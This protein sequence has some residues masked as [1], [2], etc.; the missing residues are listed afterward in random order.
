MKIPDVFP[1]SPLP[2]WGTQTGILSDSFWILPESELEAG[3]WLKASQIPGI[4][5]VNQPRRSWWIQIFK[6]QHHRV[7]CDPA[8]AA[9]AAAAVEM[10]RQRRHTA[11]NSN[12]FVWLNNLTAEE[13]EG[14][15]DCC[16]W[17]KRNETEQSRRKRRRRRR[18]R[19][20]RRRRMDQNNLIEETERSFNFDG[21]GTVWSLGHGT[22][23]ITSTNW[24]HENDVRDSAWAIVTPTLTPALIPPLLVTRNVTR[25]TAPFRFFHSV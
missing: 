20:R 15:G 6:V 4:N 11:S 16:F 23:R 9:A 3:R 13:E 2:P 21:A 14:N 8:A 24:Q 1:S 17:W 10:V 18:R 19:Q 12:W 22:R 7:G 25:V 5:P